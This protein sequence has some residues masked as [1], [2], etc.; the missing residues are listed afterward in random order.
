MDENKAGFKQ[1]IAVSAEKLEG[2]LVVPPTARSIVLFAHGSGSNRHSLRNQYVA[3]VFNN[4][5]FATL[6]VDLLTQQEKEID[7][8]SRHI[9]FNID[10]LAERLL[11]VTYWLLQN[12]NTY[13][14][15]IG[16]FGS[17][18]G[19]AAALIAAAN[20]GNTVKTIV[21]RGG[22]PDLAGA[23]GVMQHVRAPTMLIVGG[24][25]SSVITLNKSSLA[26]LGTG[27][28]E[29]AVIPGAG[30]MFDEP[31]KMEV[32]AEIATEW[33]KCYLENGKKFENKYR[34]KPGLSSIFTKPGIQIRF[35][36]RAAAGVMLASVLRK[37]EGKADGIVIGIPRGGVV[38]ADA[39]ARK[40]GFEL[41]VAFP[42]K[43]RSPGNSENAIGAIMQDGSVYVDS[44]LVES[45]MISKD[46]MEMEQSEQKK[47]IQR[48]MDLYRPGQRGYRIR[49][50]VV[51][52]VDDGAATG[53][54]VAAAARWTR[55]QEP[56][57]MIVALPVASK[58]SVK[59]LKSE[60]DD[61]QVLKQPSDFKALAQFYQDFQDVTDNQV[62]Q[63]M[64]KHS[65]LA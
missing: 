18:T 27:A 33:F 54:T 23:K 52:L 51:V 40:L 31:G 36:D 20:L 46:Y 24:N 48:R 22:R 26:Q 7:D 41:D 64:K 49:G 19:A 16:Y 25:D 56:A 4:A 28:K 15:R 14:L 37:Y 55:R 5:G 8:K 35:K 34:Y 53:A 10:L 63:I 3:Q 65:L 59:V 11:A 43:L 47:E 61:V 38:V 57:K 29:L 50:R 9:R 32:V 2:D 58:Q 39:I 30:H 13:N 44:G 60:A 6:L 17:S 45:M 12:T 21:S 1:T 62:M 42:R